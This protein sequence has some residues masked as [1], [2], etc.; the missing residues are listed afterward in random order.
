MENNKFKLEIWH[1]LIVGLFIV[2][3]FGFLSNPQPSIPSQQ[4]QQTNVEQAGTKS[5]TS[6]LYNSTSQIV[7]TTQPIVAMASQLTG[8][9]LI[10]GILIMVGNTFNMRT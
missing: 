3:L 2:G 1:G 10:I 8:I 5:Q 6:E 7:E 4:T 9:I